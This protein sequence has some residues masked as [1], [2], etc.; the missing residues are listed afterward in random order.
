MT[1]IVRT[2]AT[3]RA[4]M[5]SPRRSALV[6]GIFYLITYVSIPT[7]SLYGPVKAAD[8]A[9]G[10]A[11]GTGAQLGCFLE[12]IVALA[13]IGSAVTLFPVIRRQNEGMALGFVASRTLEGAMIFVGVASLLSL[14][15]LQQ[16]GATGAEATSLTAV[17]QALVGL[18]N[19]AF[20]VGQ[21]LMPAVNAVLLGTLLYRSRLV[22]RIIP[23][24]GLVG[25]PLQF[26]AVFLTMFGVIGRTS[27]TAAALVLPIV[28]FEL[29]VGLYLLVKGFKPSPIIAAIVSS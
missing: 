15:A 13:G 14:I 4:P 9:I 21:S 22:P 2:P 20:L 25:A 29:S 28:V 8:F 6:A 17:G 7:L 27:S 18:Y 23:V 16:P 11:A 24:F 1:T 5:S 3:K 19:G 12:V 26:T 10:T